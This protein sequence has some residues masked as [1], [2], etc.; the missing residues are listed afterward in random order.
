MSSTPYLFVYGT[1]LSSQRRNRFSLYLANNADLI[2][3]ATIPGRLYGLKRYP[4]LRPA[5]EPDDRVTG[6]V[7]RLRKPELT[8][9]TL[10]AYEASDYRR[11]RRQVA[12]EDSRVLR[13]WI[14]IYW[15]PLPRHRRIASGMWENRN[16]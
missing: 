11:I 5:L 3:F 1:L 12:L 8:L 7:H 9:R 16:S 2:G 13:C 10:D 14:Y 4:G 6:E 15:H